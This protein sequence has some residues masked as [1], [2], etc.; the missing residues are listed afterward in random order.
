MSPAKTKVHWASGDRFT[1]RSF[2][3][4][5][6]GRIV[7]PSKVTASVRFDGETVD[8]RVDLESL[9]PETED[10]IAKRDHHTAMQTWRGRRPKT[11]HT[12]SM[13]PNPEETGAEVFAKTPDEMRA[14]AAELL[15]LAD[16][17]DAKPPPR[18]PR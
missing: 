18:L 11:T 1:Y 16:W 8:Q 17:Y 4:T 5:K 10:D 7:N 14:A 2:G 12:H 9:R 3:S 6:H 15:L 13:H